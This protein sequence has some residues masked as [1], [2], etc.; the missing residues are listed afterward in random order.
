MIEV[1]LDEHIVI[2]IMISDFALRFQIIDI[3]I[4]L[5]ND[6][7][8]LLII[9]I[10]HFPLKIKIIS[11]FSCIQMMLDIQQ[12]QNLILI[13]LISCIQQ[14]NFRYAILIFNQCCNKE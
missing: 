8:I 2:L 6:F 12:L 4:K 13:L 1:L 7:E 10:I 3:Q 9:L 14:F 11:D 5:F